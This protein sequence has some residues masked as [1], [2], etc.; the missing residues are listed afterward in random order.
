[1]KLLLLHGALGA[2]VDFE[3]FLP[4]FP[5]EWEV[6]RLDFLNHGQGAFT[7]DP[8]SIPAFGG[9]L[10]EY[11]DVHQLTDVNI[12]GYSM[13]GYVASWLARREPER[14]RAIYTLGT[15]FIWTAE[16]AA[17]EASKLDARMLLNKVPTFAENLREKHKAI[18]WQLLLAQ[19]AVLMQGLGT[20]PALSLADYAQIQVPIM[21][22]RGELDKM[23]AEEEQLTVFNALKFGFTETL[24][25]TPH[26]LQQIAP[27]LLAE[28]LNAFFS[29]DRIS[30]ST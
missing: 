12:F 30:R 15:K 14:I 5:A 7:D 13:G 23:V 10:I 8:L 27:Q 28:K 26:P 1:M 3:P 24:P 22:A 21:V 17:A 2:S 20:Q 6:H 29:M 9:Q 25:Q 18:D 11:L 16:S 19:T 4:H